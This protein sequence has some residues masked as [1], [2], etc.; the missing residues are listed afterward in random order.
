LVADN[1][2]KSHVKE[3]LLKILTVIVALVFSLINTAVPLNTGTTTYDPDD[4]PTW[5]EVLEARKNETATKNK[6]AEIEKLL[7]GLEVELQAAIVEAER[8]GEIYFEKQYEYDV[9][10][11]EHEQLL[12]EAETAET[13]AAD[14]EFKTGALIVEMSRTGTFDLEPMKIFLNPDDT[15]DLLSRI[16]YADK[17][18]MSMNGILEDALA[19][20]NTASS[21]A[22]QAEVAKILREEAAV[23]A[24][25]AFM[26]AQ[27]A[28]TRVE[29]AYNNQQ[30]RSYELQLQLEA[31]TTEREMT[32]EKYKEGI[33]A[34]KA[35]EE[36]ARRAAQQSNSQN[37]ANFKPVV[38]S[39]NWAKPSSGYISSSY[40]W[41]IHPI[42]GTTRFHAGVDIA[43]RCGTPMYAASSGTVEYAG[44]LGTLG[45]FIRIN[46]G[47]GLTTGY[48]HIQS[49]GI[50]VSLGEYVEA[51]QY[52]ADMGTT[53]GSTGCHLHF[54]VRSNMVHGDPV[55][56]LRGQ[57]VGI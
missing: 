36:A 14:A 54:E 2:L 16:G 57:G 26:V 12:L 19:K 13:E 5:Q 11:W 29:T 56:F 18:S 38:S 55:P 44:W 50:K 45:Y 25:N 28:Q 39:S 52:I 47:N 37:A 42:Y 22:G 33:A 53:G 32:E 43:N 34:K 49:G 7:E 41:R 30:Q 35:A 23:V 40:G 48:A 9:A 51:G 15:G 1:G 17:V 6:I 21:L 24:E 31:L 27:E 4:Y 46:H 8:L 3:Y 20:R 10:M